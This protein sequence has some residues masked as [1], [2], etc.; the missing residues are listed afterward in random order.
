MAGFEAD[1]DETLAKSREAFE[2]AY[3]DELAALA[4]LSKEEI[5][6]IAL[7]SIDLQKY[8]ELIMVVK[9][10][11]RANLQQA[12]LKAQIEKL[13]SVAVTIAKHVPSLKNI[14]V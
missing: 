5:D 1:L 4:G 14:L 8:D 7:G 13:G 10:A 3:K 12:E 9:E 2:G 11:S 6:Q